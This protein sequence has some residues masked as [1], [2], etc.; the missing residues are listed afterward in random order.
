MPKISVVIPAH[1]AEDHIEKSLMSLKRQV[2]DDFEIIVAD[3]HSTDRT[4]EIAEQYAKVI[5]S[6]WRIGEGAARNLGAKSAK[7][8]ILAFTDADVVLPKDWL[9]KIVQNMEL[10]KVKCIGGGYRGSI[11]NSFIEVFA[12]LELAYRR[13]NMPPFVTTLVSN[14]FACYRDVFFQCGGFPEKYKCEDMRLSFEIN[15]KYAIYWDSENSIYHQFR[16][17]LVAYLRQQFHFAKD[18]VWAHYSYPEMIFR[19]T[20]QGRSIYFETLLMFFAMI[21]FPFF[22]VFIMLILMINYPFLRFLR[23]ENFPIAKS[24]CV[25]LARN[26]VCVLGVLLGVGICICNLVKRCVRGERLNPRRYVHNE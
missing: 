3:D 19:K 7:G 20:H 26:L 21:L 2:F 8:E 13:K 22:P 16:K 17:S 6:A 9:H 23:N 24:F 4:C 1:N 25:V 5:K 14:N 10:R 15:K 18:T 12:Y 11:G